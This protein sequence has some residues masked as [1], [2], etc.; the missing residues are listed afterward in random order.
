MVIDPRTL[1]EIRNVGNC[2]LIPQCFEVSEKTVPLDRDFDNR[3]GE[4]CDW[5]LKAYISI[6]YGNVLE[7]RLA[8]TGG[9]H[10]LTALL[11]VSQQRFEVPKPGGGSL[12][13]LPA[14]GACCTRRT[15]RG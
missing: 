2:H 11:T 15:D 14:A 7:G 9:S 10:N 6:W 4:N 5:Q 8:V 13:D 12:E 1:R 3:M